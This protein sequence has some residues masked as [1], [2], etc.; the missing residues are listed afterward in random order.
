MLIQIAG[1]IFVSSTDSGQ[2]VVSFLKIKPKDKNKKA[3]HHPQ[4]APKSEKHLLPYSLILFR[5]KIILVLLHQSLRR[6]AILLKPLPILPPHHIPLIRILLHIVDLPLV[7]YPLKIDQIRLRLGR[8]F[9]KRQRA[10]LA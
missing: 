3:H 5:L 10:V 8:F 1:N 2:Q 7:G 4:R 6:R 9:L